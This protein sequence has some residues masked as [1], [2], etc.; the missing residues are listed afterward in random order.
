KG[1]YANLVV[2]DGN[3][4][5]SR[6]QVRDVWIDGKRHEVTP[7]PRNLKGEREVTLNPPPK[8]PE[9]ASVRITYS[10]DKDNAITIRKHVKEG[11]A[12]PKIAKASTRNV[13]VESSGYGACAVPRRV[14]F[15]FE[16]EPFGDPGM[17]L[18]A[19]V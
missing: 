4:F 5:K 16:H 13:R 14:S 9:G 8:G 7:A 18:V 6:A 17:Y 10:I 15:V 12:E 11:N 3:I 19:G 1:K 2:T